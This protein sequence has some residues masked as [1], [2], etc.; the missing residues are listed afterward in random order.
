MKKFIHFILLCINCTFYVQ[1]NAELI[2]NFANAILNRNSSLLTIIK[3]DDILRQKDLSAESLEFFTHPLLDTYWSYKYPIINNVSVVYSFCNKLK[4]NIIFVK[5]HKSGFYTYDKIR[6]IPFTHK[7][8]LWL[9]LLKPMYDSKGK[10]LLDD[11]EMAYYK[12]IEKFNFLNKHT[13]F[14]IVPLETENAI[15]LDWGVS[16][17]F[18][19][20]VEIIQSDMDLLEDIRLFESKLCGKNLYDIDGI[21]YLSVLKGGIKTPIGKAILSRMIN[22]LENDVIKKEFS[23]NKLK[24]P[25]LNLDKVEK[26]YR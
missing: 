4:R 24:N 2:D 10:L 13:F 9:V 16:D 5:R 8:S 1:V 23:D 14:Q 12:D 21:E 15:C 18:Q 25:L 19:I 11:R 20:P 3:I 17:N 26:I 22:I 6:P 7:D